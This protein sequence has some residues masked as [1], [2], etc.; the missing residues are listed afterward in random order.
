MPEKSTPKERAIVFENKS[1]DYFKKLE[2]TSEQ[3]VQIPKIALL[4]LS[5]MILSNRRA[6]ILMLFFFIIM[7]KNNSVCVTKKYIAQH[8]SISEKSVSTAVNFLI[9]QKWIQKSTSAAS[10]RTNIYTINSATAWSKS[11]KLISNFSFSR[12]IKSLSSFL[13]N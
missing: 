4:E 2:K 1:S 5:D 12:N 7:D 9:G 13:K 10:G 8:L 11:R 3:W 6:A